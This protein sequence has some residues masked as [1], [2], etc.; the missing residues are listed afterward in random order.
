MI[1]MAIVYTSFSV[2]TMSTFY[3]IFSWP[4]T[5][6]VRVVQ[7]TTKFLELSGNC[8]SAYGKWTAGFFLRTLPP[9][10]TSQQNG[11]PGLPS[12]N[13]LHIQLFLQKFS[14]RR[15]W[16]HVLVYSEDAVNLYRMTN[17]WLSWAH[18]FHMNKPICS[19]TSYPTHEKAT[20]TRKSRRWEYSTIPY[21]SNTSLPW[22][23]VMLITLGTIWEEVCHIFYMPLRKPITVSNLQGLKKE[24]PMLAQLME[25]ILFLESS[26][27]A[28]SEK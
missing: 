16:S 17:N 13:I 24:H 8:T 27:Q 9:P 1:S 28:N 4:Q 14:S 23:N 11:L 5:S 7:R 12:R 15:L 6:G 21:L 2:Q 25:F 19:G 22:S 3:Y 18:Q 26:T 10:P 20:L